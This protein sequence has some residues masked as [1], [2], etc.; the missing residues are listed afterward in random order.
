M[1]VQGAAGSDHRPGLN[2]MLPNL[3]YASRRLGNVSARWSL[4]ML[5]GFSPMKTDARADRAVDRFQGTCNQ[6]Q[7]PE[8]QVADADGKLRQPGFH[9]LR[10]TFARVALAA[11]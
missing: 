3:R 10:C 5:S 4:R 6:V 11:A 2:L 1:T 7:L 8:G 9:D